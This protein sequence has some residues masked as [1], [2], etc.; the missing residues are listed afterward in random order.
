MK[1][2]KLIRCWLVIIYYIY[3]YITNYADIV[4]NARTFTDSI[5]LFSNVL[6]IIIPTILGLG[7]QDV[8]KCRL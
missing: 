4:D 7:S 3:I 1:G 2:F 8:R 5:V 6:Y